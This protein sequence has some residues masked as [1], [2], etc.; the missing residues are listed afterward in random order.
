MGWICCRFG[1]PSQ[2]RPFRGCS[3]TDTSRMGGAGRIVVA[4]LL[5]AALAPAVAAR[6]PVAVYGYPL[7]D[8]CPAEG[9]ADVIDRWKMYS[10]N[11]TSY[12]A[13]ALQANGQR[14]DRFVPGAI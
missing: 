7:A 11:C 1:G 14:V 3:G 8:R 10:C 12:V 6:A 4:A 2:S 9:I 13:W 5:A